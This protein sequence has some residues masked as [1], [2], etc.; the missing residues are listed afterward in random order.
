MFTKLTRKH[1]LN[2]HQAIYYIRQLDYGIFNSFEVEASSP[3]LICTGNQTTSSFFSNYL[4]KC[5]IPL[6]HDVIHST[7]QFF[8]DCQH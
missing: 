5:K 7:I 1:V 3:C 4:L 2:S 8:V 6:S